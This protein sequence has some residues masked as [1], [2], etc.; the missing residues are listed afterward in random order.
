MEGDAE[1][2]YRST[3]RALS[4]SKEVPV[5]GLHN[6]KR[7]EGYHG[8]AIDVASSGSSIVNRLARSGAGR[9]SGRGQKRGL[10]ARRAGRCTSPVIAGISH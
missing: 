1:V 10:I 3:G 9:I 7:Q 2:T 4:C 6:D 8:R 5:M